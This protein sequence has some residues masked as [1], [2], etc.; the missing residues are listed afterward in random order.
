MQMSAINGTFLR[1]VNSTYQFGIVDKI[2]NAI[3]DPMFKSIIR[4][5]I[6]QDLVQ[7]G[8][9]T[10]APVPGSSEKSV[11]DMIAS[12]ITNPVFANAV[13]EINTGLIKPSPPT[14]TD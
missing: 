9:P 2:A 13:H 5:T 14:S 8:I 4:Y 7:R 3:E 12:I 11:L 10:D 6:N 1:S